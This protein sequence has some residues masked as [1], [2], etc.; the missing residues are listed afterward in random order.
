MPNR[1]SLNESLVL[2]ISI[3]S[4]TIKSCLKE[5]LWTLCSL[6]KQ[7]AVLVMSILLFQNKHFYAQQDNMN[8][9]LLGK[10]RNGTKD[11]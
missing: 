7:F 1:T 8:D 11:F 2:Y 4:Q 9:I 3:F 5:I 10:E 6:M